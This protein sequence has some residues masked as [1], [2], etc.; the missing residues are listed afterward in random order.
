MPRGPSYMYIYIY[1]YKCIFARVRILRICIYISYIY[2]YTPCSGC[3][4]ILFDMISSF[5]GDE[6]CQVPLLKPV[7]QRVFASLQRGGVQLSCWLSDLS[8]DLMWQTKHINPPFGDYDSVWQI[9]GHG[10]LLGFPL[11][12]TGGPLNGPFKWSLAAGEV[13][14]LFLLPLIRLMKLLRL[15]SHWVLKLLTSS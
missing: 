13:G 12:C 11:Y 5:W 10:L 14:L 8:F 6:M 1:I 2:I 9:I 7:Q 15:S 3:E 4:L